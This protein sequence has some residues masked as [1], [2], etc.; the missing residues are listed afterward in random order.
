MYRYSLV[1][2]YVVLLVLLVM[3]L[4]KAV[5]NGI[6]AKRVAKKRGLQHEGFWWG[7]YLGTIGIIVMRC[8]PKY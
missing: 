3:V 7:F 1:S 2:Y 8:C 6:I 4:I 5:I